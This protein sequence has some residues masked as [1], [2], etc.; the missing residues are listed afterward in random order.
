M[1]LLRTLHT[2]ATGSQDLFTMR[3]DGGRVLY[4]RFPSSEDPTQSIFRID[5]DGTDRRRLTGPGSEDT[6]PDP[7]P[8]PRPV[9]ERLPRRL[10]RTRPPAAVTPP[11]EAGPVPVE[12][13][14]A[15]PH[16]DGRGRSGTTPPE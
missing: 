12:P 13:T 4:W 14:G 7:F 15:G 6:E 8:V 10:R 5:A 2:R 3:A 1:R 9:T 16:Q 11:W